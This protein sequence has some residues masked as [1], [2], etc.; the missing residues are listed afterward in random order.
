VCRRFLGVLGWFGAKRKECEVLRRKV[1]L[2]SVFTVP[3]VL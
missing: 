1:T 2:S 3:S